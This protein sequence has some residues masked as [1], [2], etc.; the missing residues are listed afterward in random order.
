MTHKWDME[1]VRSGLLNMSEQDENV[2]TDCLAHVFW[3]VLDDSCRHFR[4][5]LSPEA[6]QAGYM[7]PKIVQ[8]P[9]TRLV[10]KAKK[11]AC[12]EPLVNVSVPIQ[13]LG[14]GATVASR[15]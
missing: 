8:I 11:L 2:G 10:H 1:A 15:V 14:R 7:D 5:P 4:N 12:N 13:G 6:A 9:G 3:V